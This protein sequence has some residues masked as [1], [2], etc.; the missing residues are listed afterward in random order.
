MKKMILML[1]IL[2]ILVIGCS[3]GKESKKETKIRII[4]QMER[5]VE[6]PPRVERIVSLWPEAT[7]VLLALGLRIKL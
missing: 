2:P 7:R 3:K 5:E 6:V 4:D 1:L